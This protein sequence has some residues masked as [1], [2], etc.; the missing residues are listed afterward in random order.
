MKKKFF[1][2]QLE[3]KS[4]SIKDGIGTFEGY[5]SV[6]GNKDSYGDI[7]TRG[8]FVNSLAKNGLPAM[9]WQHWADKPI[10]VWS[11]AR[12]DAN[13]LFVKG[14]IN[15]DVQQGKEAYALIQQ[16]AIKGLS[17]GFITEIDEFD[18]ATG[19]RYIKQVNL[20]EVSIVT[21]PANKLANVVGWKEDME[22][23]DTVRDFEKFL[24]LAGYSR[25]QAKAIASN[26]FKAASDNLRDA[27]E[28]A[29]QKER[30]ALEELSVTISNITSILKE[31]KSQ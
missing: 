5:A 21:F 8:A 7:V 3:I 24:C 4:F 15:L 26:G 29:Q 22:L 31:G 1:D 28:Q 19:I 27:D 12:E 10:G 18:S 11:E 23:P 25:A 6:F 20:L 2:V 13:G 16:G 30:E 9:L 17:I 14:E